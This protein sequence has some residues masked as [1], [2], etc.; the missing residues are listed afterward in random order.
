MA[1]ITRSCS[2]DPCNIDVSDLC[3]PEEYLYAKGQLPTLKRVL[4]HVIHIKN[5]QPTG[6][7]NNRSLTVDDILSDSSP[8]SVCSRL[9]DLWIE[10]NI[11]PVSTN[12]I[13]KNLKKEWKLF[14]QTQTYCK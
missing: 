5:I 12:S 14:N 1:K 8:T 13:S 3:P 11:Y 9:Y 10:Q 6:G 2:E 4:G 7:H